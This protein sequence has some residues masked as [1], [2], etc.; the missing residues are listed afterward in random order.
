M[1]KRA[2]K[3]VSWVAAVAMVVT[4][5]GFTAPAFAPASAAAAPEITGVNPDGAKVAV[6]WNT[7][8]HYADLQQQ[9]AD[10]NEAYPEY[11]ELSTI[12]KTYRE[13]DLICMTIT[14]ESVAAKKKTEVTVFGNI[15]GGEGESAAC[16][17]YSAWYLL[18]NSANPQI[19]DLLKK[20]IVYV[21]PV[22]NPD[23]YEQSFLY[24]TRENANPE[25]CDKDG[26]GIPYGDNYADIN[27]D[28]M[29][30]TVAPLNFDPETGAASIPNR[31]SFGTESL[32]SNG[33]GRLGDDPQNSGIDLNRNFDY[34]W[35]QDGRMDTEGP[36]AAS[37]LET[38]AIQNFVDSHKDMAGLITLHTGIQC[39][40]YPW[41][42]RAYD[43]EDP[44]DV[45]EL[46]FM[47][48]TATAMSTAIKEATGRNF[49]AKQSF[50]DYQT[51][52][53]L[54]DYAY[55]LY[56]IHAYTIEVYCGGSYNRGG[57]TSEYDPDL[58]VYDPDGP[59]SIMPDICCW[60]NTLP[61]TK[62][63]DY[64]HAEAVAMFEAAGIDYSKLYYTARVDGVQQQI[65]WGEDQGIR[66]TYNST[67]QMCGKAPEEQDVM[68]TGVMEGILTMFYSEN[69][70]PAGEALEAA[71]ADIIAA[72]ETLAS[73]EYTAE[74]FA[75]VKD[76]ID[77]LNALYDSP[78]ATASEVSAAQAALVAAWRTLVPVDKAAAAEAAAVSDAVDA[79]A[80]EL[81]DVYNNLDLK[82]YKAAG[83]EA[84]ETAIAEAEAALANEE[85][86][87]AELKAAKSKL[88]KT[89]A[90][91]VK[92][93]AQPWKVSVAKKTV[94]VAKVKKAKQTVKAITVKGAV[95]KVT[96]KKAGGSAKLTVGTN[97]KITVK[98]GTKK[99][100]YSVKVK[101]KAA[102][103]GDTLAATK[104]V[105][106]KIVVKK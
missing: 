52:S 43:P 76:A 35:G 18:E 13:R 50:F 17:M 93:D 41:G 78:T 90:G 38:Q 40:L 98:K 71:T 94:K 61:S 1:S 24:R 75:A 65:P 58:E 3:I 54:I 42:Y 39:T 106:V 12:G 51:Y 33:N 11:S 53:E 2:K 99:G 95:G 88:L 56:G 46:G 21:I 9:F 47:K 87:S 67:Q 34:L 6:D 103:D 79:L 22:I 5:F 26:D 100:T 104:T 91:L 15:H 73:G 72:T 62:T 7:R 20:Y 8:Y 30:G 85:S 74:S 63:V 80:K 96:Y 14:D 32:D 19:Q 102:G 101:I 29:I 86:T 82:K 28:G 83:V 59:N 37:E 16:A 81:I 66:I 68:V 77:A 105:T 44:Q 31:A 55:G 57:R 49:Y 84:M 97:G 69:P 10:L 48:E 92:K 45:E 64:T 70:D 23:G 4:T 60:N 25:F 27:G 36:S 89:W